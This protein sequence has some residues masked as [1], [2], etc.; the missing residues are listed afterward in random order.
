MSSTPDA[1]AAFLGER[2]MSYGQLNT[3][4]NRLARLLQS[5]GVGPGARVAVWMNRSPECLAALLAVMKAGAAYVPIDLSL[6]IRRVQYILQDSQA[7]LVLVDEEGQGRL[8]ELELSAMTAVDVCGTLDGEEANLDLPCDP[9]QPVY[10]IYTSGST[11]S[12]KGVLVRHSGLANYVAWAKRQY[13]TA[14][15]TSFA[16]YSSLSFDLT[17]TSIYV[18]LVAG[19][20]VHVYP[21]QGD[22]VPVINR[23]LDD[24]QVDVI[25]LTPS[26]ML[27][28]RN[29]ALATSRL[30][31]LIVGGEDLKA[32]LAYDI[33]QRFRRDVAI[34]NEY[35][36]T[37]TVVGCAIHRYD[38]AT[39]REGSVPIGVPIDH[40]S[41][42]LLDERL[43]PVAPGEVGQI[44]IGGA[45]VAIGYVNKPEITDA[46]FIDNP[47]EGGGRLYASGD[48]GR[49]RADGKLEF[50]GRKDSQIK[51]RGYRIELGEIE[52]VL[53]GHAALRECIVNTTV[54]PRRDYDS[55]S[56]RYCARCGIASNFPNTSF[57]EHG[58]C[59]HCHAYDKYRNVVEDYFRTEDE[60][61]TIFEQVKAHNRPRYDCLVAFS[62][63]KDSTYA[64]CRVV[65]MGLRVLAYTLDNGYISDEAK[66]NVD[67]VVREL[68]V[69]HRYLGTPH[70]N[71]IFVDS[72]NRHSNVC[73]GCFKTIYTLGINLAHEVGVSDI[74]MGLSK[75]QLFETRLS[76]LFRASTFDNQVFE[77]NLME[78]RKI[79]H[80]I[81]DAAARLLDTSCVRNDRLLE[82]TRFIDF[83][84]YCS[85]SR[86]DMYRYIAERVG[87]SRPADTGRSTNCLLNDVGIYM[88]KKQR[89]YHNY[90]LPYSWDVRVGHIPREDAMRELE[91]T[92]D[93]DEAK[94]LGLLKQIG[95]DSS[96]IDTQAGDAQLIAYYVA[97]EELDP[98]ALRNFAAA[99]LPEYMLPSYFVR[100]DRMPLTPNGK[101]NRRALPRPELKKNASE[102]HTEP[103]SALEQELVQIWKEVL[104]VDKVG[105]RD[106]FFELG[107]HSLSALM[108]LY[109]IAERYQKMVSI[110][111]FSVNP[112]IEGLSEHLVA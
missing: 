35:G 28:L 78:A 12:P 74:V 40:T 13:V 63:G 107:G 84:R 6:P 33:H 29:A 21:E 23:V 10:C 32:A 34:Y 90:S 55:K 80:R 93:I 20:C 8:G 18:P 95:Y 77:K 59:N 7:R 108:L 48:L 38:P 26:H 67:R 57:D 37:E 103:S 68:G 50:L 88:H 105:V 104:M 60:L 76:E 99:I 51:L 110:Q 102:A 97:A 5:Q 39:E 53:L 46:Q 72:L 86:K 54:A 56:L 89:G 9:A 64:L 106:N 85:V 73:N 22:D 112:T 49:M 70:M 61:R 109:S 2:R 25:K 19:L 98:V 16:F 75:G 11:G 111:A 47:F 71:A 62:G 36:P 69:D 81:D 87:W 31:T 83:Y 79:Y 44:H 92:D 43:Q 94:V 66:A 52:N 1:P 101:V 96:L 4:A 3:R 15:T 30:K 58:V 82:S 14:D 45:G 41:L 100:L 24:N 91:D 42:H 27:M 17:V 65:D